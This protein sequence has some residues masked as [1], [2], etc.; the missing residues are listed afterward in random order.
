MKN[1]T[2]KVPTLLFLKNKNYTK[3]S[4]V[5]KELIMASFTYFNHNYLV[6]TLR[7]VRTRLL[8]WLPWQSLSCVEH[9][10][11]HVEP[12]EIFPKWQFYDDSNTHTHTHTHGSFISLHNTFMF[13]KGWVNF[14]AGSRVPMYSVECLGLRLSQTY[15]WII[16]IQH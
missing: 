7:P 1:L 10:K 5:W 3:W 9:F 14:R 4:C 2:W 13:L 16:Q 11:F 12:A 15:L 6:C 8:K